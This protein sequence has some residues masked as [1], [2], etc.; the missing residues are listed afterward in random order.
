MPVNS[1]M[2]GRARIAILV[3][4]AALFVVPVLVRAT[5][6][7][8]P[9]SPIRLNRGFERPPA[10]SQLAPPHV[11][12]LRSPSLDGCEPSPLDRDLPDL[13]TAITPDPP[14][15]SPETRGPPAFAHS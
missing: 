5:F 14:E 15:R 3:I 9:S 4:V 8:S 11:A 1:S 2:A 12:V 7:P 10:K 13:D 6:S